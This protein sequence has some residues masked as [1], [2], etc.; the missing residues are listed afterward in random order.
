ML[1][2]L[3]AVHYL[4]KDVFD[5]W[6]VALVLTPTVLAIFTG[7][8]VGNALIFRDHRQRLIHEYSDLARRL[9]RRNPGDD[10]SRVMSLEEWE[11]NLSILHGN[12]W[13]LSTAMSLAGF[14]SAA[15][16]VEEVARDLL[17][18]FRNATR[19]VFRPGALFAGR[20]P[21]QYRLRIS[22]AIDRSIHDFFYVAS[23]PRGTALVDI[24]FERM[25]A[26]RPSVPELLG[27]PNFNNVLA[28]S[29]AT[30]R[31][32]AWLM[33]PFVA[34]AVWIDRKY[35][36]RRSDCGSCCSNCHREI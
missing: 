30:R 15:G 12:Y 1:E 5:L 24:Y 10:Q 35:A 23:S 3:K 17:I 11:E 20:G 27:A 7:Y 25:A 28:L 19:A 6:E 14:P 34:L 13:R 22:R 2:Y 29:R 8:F 21:A 9:V 18:H 31:R 32:V 26:I 4:L 16:K 36:P 33:Q